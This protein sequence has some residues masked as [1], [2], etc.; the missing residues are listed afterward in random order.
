MIP[1]ALLNTFLKNENDKLPIH[2]YRI[3][4][5]IAMLHR[6]FISSSVL[7]RD[8][9][10]AF[11]RTLLQYNTYSLIYNPVCGIVYLVD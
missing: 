7:Y 11:S 2:V 6:E 3:V 9:R 8:Y 1:I 5:F 4:S 10:K